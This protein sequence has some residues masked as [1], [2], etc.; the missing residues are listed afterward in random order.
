MGIPTIGEPHTDG[1]Q[2]LTQ[3]NIRIGTALLK[4]YRSPYGLECG[5]R[6]LYELVVAWDGP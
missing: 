3:G 1:W 5:N 4:A 6:P 2:T